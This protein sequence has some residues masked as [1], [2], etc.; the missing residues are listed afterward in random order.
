MDGNNGADKLLI[1]VGSVQN[2]RPILLI[3]EQYINRKD[4]SLLKTGG[5]Q[6]LHIHN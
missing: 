5:M 3:I 1:T 2:V 4:P 6:G